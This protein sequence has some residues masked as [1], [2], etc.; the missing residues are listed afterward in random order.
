ML[1]EDRSTQ[2]LLLSLDEG[3]A[4]HCDEVVFLRGEPT[5]HPDIETLIAEA[6]ARGYSLIQLQSNG[7]MFAIP[8]FAEKLVEQGMTHVEV[9]LYGHT[10]SVHD[11]IAAVPGAFEQTCAGIRRLTGLGMITHLNIPLVRANEDSLTEIVILAADLGAMRLQFNFQR[12]IP[13]QEGGKP[14][15]GTRLHRIK[16]PLHLALDKAHQLGVTCTTEGIPFC[17]LE[18]F[19]SLASDGWEKNKMPL[20]RIDD[21]QRVTEDLDSLRQQYRTPAAVCSPCA[22][23]SRCPITWSEY[24]EQYGAEELRPIKSLQ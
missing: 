15:S 17:I 3:R 19:S 9:S 7:R 20:F 12:P 2:A 13:V 11:T 16:K 18:S 10:P 1:H 21:F 6:K 14:E 24:L 23:V 4:A 5:I 8:G 22:E